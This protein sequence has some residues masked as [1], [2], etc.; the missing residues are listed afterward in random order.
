[1]GG[2]RRI[3]AEEIREP[4]SR[5]GHEEEVNLTVEAEDMFL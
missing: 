1:M 2:F 5:F 4:E 3:V